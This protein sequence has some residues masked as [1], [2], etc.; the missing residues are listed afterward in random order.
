MAAEFDY[1]V[2]GAGSAGCVLAARLSEDAG[3]RVALV[4][5]GGPDDD[6]DIRVPLHAAR[7]L[8]TSMD[9]GFT[10]V[11]QSGLAGR[12]VYWPR[13]KVVGGSSSVNFQ[14]WVPG[15]RDDYDPWVA[16]AGPEWSWDAVR[17]YFRR[18]ERWA[19]DQADGH[20]YGTDGPLWI[21]PPRD[22]DP[23]TAR[24]LDAC[25]DLGLKEVP[26]GIGGPDHTGS[27]LTPLNQS[28]GARWSAADGYLRPALERGNLKVLTGAQVRRVLLHD[29][30]A[31][32]VELAGQTL[33][34]RRE[35]IL[36]AGAVGSPHL[37][38][39]SG[40]GDADHLRAAGVTPL[41]DLSGVGRN[42]QD[43]VAV[44]LVRDAAVPVRL[45]TADTPAHRE[46]YDQHR[47][48]P[49]TSNMTEAVA[50]LRADGGSGPPDLELI[51]APVAF[52]EE[53]PTGAGFTVAVVLLQPDSTGRITL[54]DADPATPPRIDPGYLTEPSDVDR[55]RAGLRFADR[56]LRGEALSPLLADQPPLP[57]SDDELG[58]LVRA[59]AETLFHPVGTCRA[60]RADD[61]DAVVDP[62]LRVRG[63]AGL[64]VVDAAVMPRLPRGHTHA[65]TVMIAERAADLIRADAGAPA[66]ADHPPTTREP[67]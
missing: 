30:R 16:A 12:E 47:L 63:V 49:L 7:L 33:T 43:H 20:T 44:D 36:C 13:G 22:P 48:G 28:N 26:G 4:E 57:G 23:S 52:T 19:G 53:G 45:A 32:G 11:P 5:A 24:F 55:L 29:G 37:L 6:P 3:V 64:R 14:M 54:A 17:P 41:V 66:A 18:S 42:L 50:F 38:M 21:S 62:H 2:V 31:T 1:I 39:L 46:R 8:G 51:W 56:L 58:E 60:G 10:T 65:T 40:I 27:S 59:R 25:A 67:A 15:H 61:P 9:W 35:V 34:A